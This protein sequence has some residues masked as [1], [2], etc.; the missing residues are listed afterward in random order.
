MSETESKVEI[1]SESPIPNQQRT[2]NPKKAKIIHQVIVLSLLHLLFM[3]IEGFNKFDTQ[4]VSSVVYSLLAVGTV[5]FLWIQKENFVYLLP[6]PFISLCV[7]G[8]IL[9][10]TITTTVIFVAYC[11]YF[12][13][14]QFFKKK[15]VET[16]LIAAFSGFTMIILICFTL[17]NH[18][19]VNVD[20]EF[21]VILWI[22]LAW[23][24]TILGLAFIHRNNFKLHISF[25][26][27]VL[28]FGSLGPIFGV[29]LSKYNFFSLINGI[30]IFIAMI[31]SMVAIFLEKE[32]KLSKFSTYIGINL[33][34]IIIYSFTFRSYFE[35]LN[36]FTSSF[37]VDYILLVPLVLVTAIVL[38]L[39]FYPKTKTIDSD[40]QYSFLENKERINYDMLFLVTYLV[41][42]FSSLITLIGNID[43]FQYAFLKALIISFVF[44]GTTIP[45]NVRISTI[46]S[47]LATLSFF[48]TTLHF[49]GNVASGISLIVLLSIAIVLLIFT[50]INEIFLKGEPLSTNLSMVATLVGLIA[51]ILYFYIENIP[52]KEIWTSISWA[53]IGVF[54]FAFGIIFKRL[55]L[56]RS[57]LAVVLLDIVYSIISISLGYKGWEMG[58]AYI[59][60]AIVLM[61][62]IYLF[63]WSEKREEK[64]DIK[65]NKI[66]E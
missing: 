46:I 42:L 60:L 27:T 10:E 36:T 23:C 33:I 2:I 52:L 38:T 66:Q 48:I 28:T 29:I 58:I 56:R 45:L 4:W 50:A 35:W 22:W 65:E 8:A 13:S 26:A 7:V 34:A 3:F 44:V 6:I 17:F 31:L 55:F 47:M 59:I 61:I 30:I 14:V 49:L 39:K 41:F 21:H 57:G 62:C 43:N 11:G 9:E 18:G 25:I 64:T 19:F 54:L 5:I 53:I 32:F 37:L 12:F 16:I 63:R 1:I 51:S 40:T 20:S 24:L 15:E